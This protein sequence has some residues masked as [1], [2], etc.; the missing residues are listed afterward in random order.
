MMIRSDSKL[1]KLHE[2]FKKFYDKKLLKDYIKLEDKR[3]KYL[4]IFWFLL[5]TSILLLSAIVVYTNNNTYSGQGEKA[6][7]K[8][9]IIIAVF[10][11]IYPIVVFK[12]RTQKTVMNKIVSFFGDMKYGKNR[13]KRNDIEESELFSFY[14]S[15][16][17]DDCFHGKYNDVSIRVSEQTLKRRGR[18]NDYII[19]SGLFIMLDFDKVFSGKTIVKT[20]GILWA[21]VFPWIFLVLIYMFLIFSLVY[22]K[23]YVKLFF[24]LLFCIPFIFEIRKFY[25]NKKEVKLEDVVFS[26]EWKVY[27]TDQ[28]EA[29]YLLTTAFMERILEIKRRFNG[30]KID[31]SF[32]DNKLF[33]A[34]HT[35]KDMFE[36]TNLFKST[37]D[38]RTMQN[39]VYQFYSIFSIIDLLKIKGNKENE[40]N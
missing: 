30:D 14:S 10:L 12:Q 21:D 2:D 37:L 7:V 31:F 32:F 19:F 35:S 22:S 28:V 8:I 1:Q 33:I 11:V 4:K 39:V 27:A 17:V 9:M 6:F 24:S 36:T 25:A 16:S 34:V 18:K 13:I 15:S 38:Y 3:K 29:R 5:A 26:K 20:R 40:T 23:E